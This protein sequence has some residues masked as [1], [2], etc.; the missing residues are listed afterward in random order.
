MHPEDDCQRCGGNNPTWSVASDRWNLAVEA[1]GL[2][3][4]AMLC[5]GCFVAGHQLAT[6]M[7]CAWDLVPATPFRWPDTDEDAG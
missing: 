4:I 7:R 2:T 1:L 5:P 3:S 6:G